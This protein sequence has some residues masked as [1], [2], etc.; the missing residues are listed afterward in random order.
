L[1]SPPSISFPSTSLFRSSP[2]LTQ[3]RRNLRSSARRDVDECGGREPREATFYISSVT[4]E[5]IGVQDAV[6]VGDAPVHQARERLAR[7]R[8]D[9]KSTRLNSSHVEISY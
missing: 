1:H 6:S 3:E 5:W 8:K 2:R 7:D 9:R 4:S